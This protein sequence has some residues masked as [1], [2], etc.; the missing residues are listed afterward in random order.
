MVFGLL[1]EGED[2]VD[3]GDTGSI[4]IVE[5]CCGAGCSVELLEDE[6]GWRGASNVEDVCSVG[7]PSM[8]VVFVE[9]SVTP[10]T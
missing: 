4:D 8:E 7:D 2:G 3:M 1:D 9:D 10:I 6:I 5:V